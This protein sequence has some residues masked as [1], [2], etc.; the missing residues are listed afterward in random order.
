MDKTRSFIPDSFV[1][2]LKEM[3]N[4]VSVVSRYIPLKKAGRNFQ[5]LCPFHQ[6]KTPSFMVNE[7]KQI[8]HCFGC[9]QGGNVFGFLMQFH[10]LSF[11]EAVTELAAL[12]GLEMP[13][14]PAGREETAETR[15]RE[16]LI[17]IQQLAADFYRR[18]LQ[19]GPEGR[20]GRAYLEARGLDGPTSEVFALGVA[21]AAWDRLTQ[22]LLK[23]QVPKDL[24]E[25]SGLAVKNERG[26]LYDRFRNR[27]MFPI[28]DER[29]QVVA[30]GGRTLGEDSPKYL[31]SPESVLFSK[32]RLLY[33]FA[34]ARPAIR[35]RKQVLIVEGY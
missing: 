11:P 15:K 25:Q 6:E 20:R 2:Q 26:G 16:A 5:G 4:I 23:Q 9:G 30:F 12:Q 7:E 19:E 32:G 14:A 31:N 13:Q 18:C 8:F 1:T 35:E 27:L 17:R 33:G 3:S 29:K 28:F 24:L 10:N 21:P 34:Q 22:A